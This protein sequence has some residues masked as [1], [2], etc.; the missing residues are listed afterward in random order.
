[1][2]PSTKWILGYLFFWTILILSDLTILD[3]PSVDKNYPCW[4]DFM[5]L[6]T[7][8]SFAL[9]GSNQQLA[10]YSVTRRPVLISIS[11]SLFYPWLNSTMKTTKEN[12]PNFINFIVKIWV[13]E[14]G[15]SLD[16]ATKNLEALGLQ[17]LVKNV[18]SWPSCMKV[19]PS[20]GLKWGP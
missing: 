17:T 11:D 15:K 13:Q 9:H 4:L 7:N 8:D 5:T 2:Y 19:S 10:L 14:K 12:V 3:S 20:A 16:R 6:K 1:M 18:E